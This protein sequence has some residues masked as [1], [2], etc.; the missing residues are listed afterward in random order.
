MNLPLPEVR[1]LARTLLES[2]SEGPG[3]DARVDATQRVL[4]G[5]ADRLSPL[6]GMAGFHLLLQRAIRRAQADHGWL[7]AVQPEAEE[8]QQ[9]PGAADAVRDL[10]PEVV[11]AGTE[12]AVA[13]LIGLIAR[14]LGA[15]MAIRLVRQSF[16]GALRERDP[17]F[18]SSGD[19]S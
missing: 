5:L 16:P 7:S 2:A 14:F 4:A 1:A 8:P 9:L 11:A 19:H 15:D 6:V 17:G 3:V 13:E 12:A 18:G 10:A